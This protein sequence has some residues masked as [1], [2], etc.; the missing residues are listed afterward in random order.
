MTVSGGACE[1]QPDFTAA[2]LQAAHREGISTAVEM[3]GAFGWN[4]IWS[5]AQYADYILYDLKCM[6][7][8]RHRA[9]TR[10][11]NKMILQNA[12]DLVRAGCTIRFRMPLIP[13][14]NDDPESVRKVAQFVKEE[15]GLDPVQHLELLSYNNLGEEKYIRMAYPG[16]HPHYARQSEEYLASLRV[17]CDNI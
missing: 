17:I 13:E 2:L 16:Q 7:D 1:M 9:G 12:R 14:F 3:E 10:V 11:S 4:V 8:Q 15:L 5:I 6:D